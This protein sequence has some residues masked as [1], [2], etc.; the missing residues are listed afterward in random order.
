MLW[1]TTGR[2]ATASSSSAAP[3]AN[4]GVGLKSALPKMIFSSGWCAA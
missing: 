3:G 4:G 1:I 2:S